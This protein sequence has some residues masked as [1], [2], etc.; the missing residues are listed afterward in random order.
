MDMTIKKQRAEKI[1]SQHPVKRDIAYGRL[2]LQLILIKKYHVEV[3]R[4]SE[5]MHKE[6][7]TIHEMQHNVTIR[8]IITIN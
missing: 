7:L 4:K 8:K 6:N 3:S 1:G 5:E 2:K